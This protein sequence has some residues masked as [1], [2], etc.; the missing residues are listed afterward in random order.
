ML[1][2]CLVILRLIHDYFT[3]PR[4]VREGIHLHPLAVILSILAGEQ[5]AGIPGVFLS[6]PIVALLTVLYKHFRAHTESS[7]N[8]M[9]SQWLESEK[10]SVE[11]RQNI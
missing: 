9:F 2:F 6:I 8:G 3:Y 11:N 1:Q 7:G 10:S 5:V 4:I